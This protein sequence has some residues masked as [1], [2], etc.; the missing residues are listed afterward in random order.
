MGVRRMQQEL[1]AGQIARHA[2]GEVAAVVAANAAVAPTKTRA[3]TWQ[4]TQHVRSQRTRSLSVLQNRAWLAPGQASAPRRPGRAKSVHVI[5]M[6]A[7]M[8]RVANAPSLQIGSNLPAVTTH[9]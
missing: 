4:A 8:R 9:R 3:V 1:T 6:V 5:V 2:P 7:I